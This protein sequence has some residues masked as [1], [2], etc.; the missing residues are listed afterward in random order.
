MKNQY[1]IIIIF[2]L[3]IS[4]KLAAQNTQALWV[5]RDMLQSKSSIDEI[6]EY[7]MENKIN[8]LFVQVRG[9]GSVY[10]ESQYEDFENQELDFDPL[11]Y[12]IEKSINTNIKIHAWFNLYLIWSQTKKPESSKHPLNR[13]PDAVLKDYN[14]DNY[15]EKMKR[16]V[17]GHYLSPFHKEVNEYLLN[18]VKEL[19]INYSID[20]I[21]FDYVR[22]PNSNFI[23]EQKLLD[24]VSNKFGFSPLLLKKY[25][26]SAASFYSNNENIENLKKIQ[27]TYSK[28]IGEFLNSIYSWINEEYPQVLVSAAVKPD[29]VLAQIKFFQDWPLWLKENYLDFVVIMNYSNK[30]ELFLKNLKKIKNMVDI[31]RVMVGIGCYNKNFNQTKEQIYIAR[32]QKFFSFSFFS[33]KH[34]KNYSF[35]RLLGEND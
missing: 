13:F 8:I 9:R 26:D 12:I 11:A 32:Q 4:I 10:Y 7:A 28:V 30:N 23:V 33:Y 35:I 3:F 16:T 1:L 29:P 19:A 5:V 31:S 27:F 21:H 2:L 34:L 14:F 22:Y 6:V 15:S 24:Y 17:E 25:P 18:M 20:G